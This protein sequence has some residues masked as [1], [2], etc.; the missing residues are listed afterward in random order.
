MSL[1]NTPH[2]LRMT[3]QNMAAPL[4]TGFP[5]FFPKT[6]DIISSFRPSIFI[7]RQASV[8]YFCKL[9]FSPIE[10][11]K[12]K[13]GLERVCEVRSCRS[14]YQVCKPSACS[15]NSPRGP[16]VPPPLFTLKIIYI[17]L[18]NRLHCVQVKLH[19]SY[20]LSLVQVAHNSL[21]M[22]PNGHIFEILKTLLLY[23]SKVKNES[24][25]F[26]CLCLWVMKPLLNET[27][28]VPYEGCKGFPTLRV[29]NCAVSKCTLF[30][31]R[32]ST[33]RERGMQIPLSQV[34]LFTA[35]Q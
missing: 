29:R 26:G 13:Q 4:T 10:I 35:T 16:A 6:L 11:K 25:C 9:S 30:W 15:P 27:E 21:K 7:L 3:L 18:L 33:H 12:I 17:S 24:V 8:I 31:V 32:I 2:T 20:S 1:G 22:D 14:V 34:V 23:K 28:S 19:F 5:F